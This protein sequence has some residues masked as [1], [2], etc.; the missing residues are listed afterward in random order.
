MISNGTW[1]WILGIAAFFA[2]VVVCNLMAGGEAERQSAESTE[3]TQATTSAVSSPA[4]ATAAPKSA[5][6]PMPEASFAD[7]TVWRFCSNLLAGTL[8]SEDVAT[9]YHL[10]TAE[11]SR[12]RE[13]RLEIVRLMQEQ[14]DQGTIG[15]EDFKV[16]AE[17]CLDLRRAD[18]ETGD[19]A[20]RQPAES[21]EQVQAT[22]PAV[23]SLARTTSPKPSADASLPE[24]SLAD[25]VVWRFCSGVLAGNLT[26]SVALA[27][28]DLE[29]AE[30]SR[31][32]EV[33]LEIVRLAREQSDRGTITRQDFMAMSELCSD[34]QRADW[35]R[36]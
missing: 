7:V 26:T 13:V 3:R 17:A 20:E 8:T 15:A 4:K 5:G 10:E 22:T 32:R 16:A 31:D 35:D 11:L 12:D 21:R 24:L 9:V 33:R 36:R 28:Y 25:N 6:T 29:T 23:S 1:M 27:V 30:L 18:W 14:I 19:E 2:I 34:L